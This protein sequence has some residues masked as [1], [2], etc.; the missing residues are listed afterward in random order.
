[1]Q[2]IKNST[3]VGLIEVLITTVVVAMGL[4]SV[5]SF[6]GSLVGESRDNKTRAE[7]LTLANTKAEQLRDVI[8]ITEYDALASSVAAESID[9]VTEEFSR[10]WTVTDQTTPTRKQINVTVSWGTGGTDNQCI[11]QT[12]IAFDSVGNSIF[13]AEDGAGVGSGAGGGPSTNAESSDEISEYIDL[14]TIVTAG[15][16]VTVDGQTYIAQDVV[17]LDDGTQKQKGLKADLCSSYNPALTAFENGLLTQRLDFDSLTGKEAIELYEMQTVSSQDYCIPRVRYNGGVIIPIS[18]IVHSGATIGNGQ[19]TMILD[20]E[21]F[22]FNA[23]ETGAYCVFKPAVNAKSA[24]YVCYVGGNCEFGPVG[25]HAPDGSAVVSGADTIV[26]ECPTTALAADKVGPG[27]WRGKVGLLGVPANG[28]NVCFAE[29][30][31][32]N[33]ASLD[34]ARNYYARNSGLNEGIN[35]PYSCHDFLIIDGVSGDGEPH[36][37][38]FAKASE[39]GGFTLASKTIQR[40]VSGNNQFD[41]TIGATY[42]YSGSGSGGGSG[43]VISGSISIGNN[44]DLSSFTVE[45]DSGLGTC[46]LVGTVSANSTISYSCTQPSSGANHLY[47]TLSPWCSSGGGSKHYELAE[48]GVTAVQGGSLVIDLGTVSGNVTKNISVT[49]SSTSC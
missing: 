37:T 8:S 31:A 25:T 14:S 3:G 42:C 48:E 18:G 15:S 17:T 12:I 44:V 1:M 34:S 39:I 40:D 35:K 38:C 45:V 5:A 24:P 2:N 36:A 41:P 29:E 30:I 11:V 33:P 9:G 22:T 4:L 20:V 7:C 16:I 10:A 19:N 6:Q 43:H 27:G 26:T 21:L 46:N 32:G 47:I 13:T 49:K 28:K 23:S